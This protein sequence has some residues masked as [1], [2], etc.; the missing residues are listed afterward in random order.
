[1]NYLQN[2]NRVTNVKI[3]R[4]TAGKLGGAKDKLGDWD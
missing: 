1:M 4:V 3:N 2:G